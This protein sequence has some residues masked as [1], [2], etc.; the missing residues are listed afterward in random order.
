MLLRAGHDVLEDLV[1][2]G[3]DMDVAVGVRRTVMQDELLPPHGL[4]AHAVVEA[5]PRPALEQL[6]LTL[7]QPRLHREVGLGEKQGR[8]PVP[9]DL[10]GPAA[11]LSPLAG[12][13]FRRALCGPA[14]PSAWPLPWAWQLVS[15]PPWLLPAAC[16]WSSPISAWR[17][18]WRISA[19]TPGAWRLW[20]WRPALPISFAPSPCRWTWRRASAWRATKVSC[21]CFAP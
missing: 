13:A 3:A 8:A 14:E 5:K 19:W 4:F 17:Q 21:F 11:L 1:Q 20:P 16:A 10:R 18:L 12:M 15:L 7:G 6:R 9:P 2:R